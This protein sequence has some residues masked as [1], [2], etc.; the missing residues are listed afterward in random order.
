MDTQEEQ[1]NNTSMQTA[2][3]FN[4]GRAGTGQPFVIY[5]QLNFNV[6]HFFA[7]GSPTGNNF[8]RKKRIE[9]LK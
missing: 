4:Y 6:K 9:T 8:Q 5:P 7:L 1:D 3:S 2:S